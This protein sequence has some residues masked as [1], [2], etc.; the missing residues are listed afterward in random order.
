MIAT[1]S[2]NELIELKKV[3]FTQF[4]Q[5]WK[6][7]VEFEPLWKK[8]LES[9]QQGCKRLRLGKEK[10]KEKEKNLVHSMVRAVTDYN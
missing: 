6:N 1:V 7:P 2:V 10:E 9:V 5:Y 3:M 4:P 8:C